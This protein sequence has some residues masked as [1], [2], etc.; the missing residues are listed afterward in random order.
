MLT[1]LP[2][3]EYLGH[4]SAGVVGAVTAEGTRAEAEG[5]P[6]WTLYLGQSPVSVQGTRASVT[7]TYRILH[8]LLKGSIK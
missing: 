6:V 4:L 8:T 2:V 1:P 7:E 3:V 5:C